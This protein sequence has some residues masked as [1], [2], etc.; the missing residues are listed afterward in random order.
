MHYALV[1][2]IHLWPFEPNCRLADHNGSDLDTNQDDGLA[3][4][5]KLILRAVAKRAHGAE[6]PLRLIRFRRMLP[7]S[8]RSL[9]IGL[10]RGVL[11]VA[12]AILPGCNNVVEQ[13]T[14][15]MEGTRRWQ[16]L[17]NRGACE[18]IYQAA[19]AYFQSHETRDR[20]QQDCQKLRSRLGALTAFQSE[21][22]VSWPI[23]EVG[24]VWVRG[25]VR[26]E[27]G[28]GEAR[29]DWSLKEDRPALNNILL[30]V[31]SEEVSIPGFTGEI[32]R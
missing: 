22:D 5:E 13:S 8:Q 10:Y 1:C 11:L 21:S 20:W 24:I 14:L 23:G 6:F 7:R 25:P 16:V 9:S 4:V 18:E 3:L 28:S 30:N 2:G 27:K 17:Y 26:F 32:R 19:S 29:F 31:T 15:A 12:L